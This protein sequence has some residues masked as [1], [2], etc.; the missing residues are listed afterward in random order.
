[1]GQNFLALSLNRV[2]IHLSCRDPT[3]L[4]ANIDRGWDPD[5]IDVLNVRLN[6]QAFQPTADPN[7]TTGWGD[8]PENYTSFVQRL[9]SKLDPSLQTGATALLME[10]FELRPSNA[11]T[12]T[13]RPPPQVIPWFHNEDVRTLTKDGTEITFKE[14]KGRDQWN[15]TQ[16]WRPLY[17]EWEALYYH[18]PFEKYSF[19]EYNRFSN[20]GTSAVRYGID[21][22]LSDPPGKFQNVSHISGRNFLLPQTSS[23]LATHIAEVF[24]NT[25]PDDLINLYSLPQT[26][27]AK[28]VEAIANLQIVT[29]PMTGLTS[30]MLTMREGA[31]VKPLVQMQNQNPVVIQAAA[32]SFTDVATAAN[33]DPVKLISS[34]DVQTMLTPYGNSVALENDRSKPPLKPVTHGQLMFTQMNIIDKFGQ[35]VA[36][37]DPRPPRRD[38]D[39]PTMNPCIS[40][41]FHPGTINNVDPSKDSKAV[42]NVV[43]AQIVPDACPYLSLGPYINQ[44]ARL[45]AAFVAKDSQNRWRKCSEW[46]SPIWGWVV[47]NYADKGLQL[48]LADGTFYREARL[49]GKKKVTD[50]F[51]WLPFD[52]PT[53]VDPATQH[54]I[55]QLNHLID[56]LTQP[57]QVYLKAFF[58][59]INQSLDDKQVHAPQ[60]YATFSSAIVGKPLALVNVG[61]SLELASEPNRNWSTNNTNAP[62]RNLLQ[63]DTNA[64]FATD[65]PAG[66]TFR[67]KLG[68]AERSFDGLVGYFLSADQQAVNSPTAS[69]LDLSKLYTYFNNETQIGDPRVPLTADVHPKFTP[70]YFPSGSGNEP[71]PDHVGKFQVFGMIL[72]PFHPVHGYSAILPNKS[73]KLPDWAVEQALSKITAFFAIGPFI[74][75]TDVAPTYDETR[76]LT[77]DNVSKPIPVM[78]PAVEPTVSVPLAPPVAA[79]SGSGSAYRYLQPYMPPPPTVTITAT[80]TQPTAANTTTATAPND[81]NLATANTR[82]NPYGISPDAASGTDAAQMRLPPGPYTALEGY[83]QITAQVA[84]PVPGSVSG[85]VA[86]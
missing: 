73:I 66:Y 82:Y 26:E 60:T 78:A 29:A 39:H 59:M 62:V 31:H 70:Y 65:D 67:V 44:P 52:P 22:N 28:V 71:L 23:T 68:D 84:G 20:W 54:N 15:G 1:L 21:E 27:Q 19:K 4:L 3:L 49:G 5:F 34:M 38:A 75:P 58:S 57:D 55:V 33:L 81:P 25:N 40:D 86:A 18:I 8:G 85:T 30:H 74:S 51:K 37:I 17:V 46:E 9:V 77:S 79:S 35:A 61:W 13:A 69:D 48:F 56:K 43:H 24:K 36:V 76:A 32:D 42:A 72:D 12:T 63:L 14:D 53:T 45:N 83:A 16:P 7:K 50:G 6:D 41:T 47:V 2:L 64:Q 11:S 80:P 10:F